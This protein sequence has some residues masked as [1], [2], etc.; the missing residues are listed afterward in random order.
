MNYFF[1]SSSRRCLSILTISDK[2][3]QVS[4]HNHQYANFAESKL[5]SGE[6]ELLIIE[7]QFSPLNIAN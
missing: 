2:R 3:P 7:L 6:A 5:S 4:I 1:S